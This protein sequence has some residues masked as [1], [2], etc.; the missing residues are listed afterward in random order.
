MTVDVGPDT[1]MRR[2]PVDLELFV[3]SEDADVTTL[4]GGDDSVHDEVGTLR[5]R[6]EWE[7]SECVPEC[8]MV[9][10]GARPGV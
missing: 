2:M 6:V 1:A 5:T 9:T 7:P 4:T 8:G 10:S 3:G